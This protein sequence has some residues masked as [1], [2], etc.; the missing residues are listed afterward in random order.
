MGEEEPITV[1][2]VTPDV[3][4]GAYL[5]ALDVVRQSNE[6]FDPETIKDK[7]Q[8]LDT[9]NANAHNLSVIIRGGGNITKNEGTFQDKKWEAYQPEISNDNVNA[10]LL[11]DHGTITIKI[12]GQA[13]LN[14]DGRPRGG[15]EIMLPDGSGNEDWLSYTNTLAEFDNQGNLVKRANLKSELSGDQ[16]SNF[17]RRYQ[18]AVSRV[19]ENASNPSPIET[20]PSNT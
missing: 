17:A 20:P 1:R 18:T 5:R 10:T 6:A 16:V 2:P 9:I 12:P 8:L 13:G 11:S 19:I 4:A 7:G 15:F 14:E 3:E